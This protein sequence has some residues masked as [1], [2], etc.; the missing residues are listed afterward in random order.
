M[1][2]PAAA[3]AEPGRRPAFSRVLLT[4]GPLPPLSPFGA[5]LLEHAAGEA[6]RYALYHLGFP[7]AQAPAFRTI[8]QRLYLDARELRLLL[9]V[10]PDAGDVAGALVEPGGIGEHPAVSAALAATLGFHRLRLLRF[11]PP[12]SRSPELRTDGT[13]E[14]LSRRLRGDLARRIPR[15]GD[16]LLAELIAALNRRAARAAGEEAPPVLG[17]AAWRWRMGRGADLRLLGPPD[18]LAPSWAADPRRAEAARRALDRHPA[19]GHDRYRGRFRAAWRALLDRL[20]PVHAALARSA[21]ERGLL[22]TVEDACFLPLDRLD[23]LG[24][25]QP[26]RRLAEELAATVREGRAEHGRLRRSAEPLDLLTERQEMAPVDGER[27]EWD[28]APLLP[29]P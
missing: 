22:L 10:R 5:T 13:P 6:L 7:L 9:A 19:P 11:L 27:P 8:R 25:A 21:V 24:R 23:D 2:S 16:A 4:P 29:L 20:A 14:E 17:R 18:P 28:W 15:L 1:L 12:G 26:P 3:Q